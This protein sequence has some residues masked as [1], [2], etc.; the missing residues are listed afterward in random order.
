MAL[1]LLGV[2]I[3]IE[4]DAEAH[5]IVRRL[6]GAL[7]T[8]SRLLLSHTVTRPD[9]PDADA[10]VAF[11][12]GHGTLKPTRRPPG[13]VAGFFDGLQ[14][15]GPGGVPCN[16]WHPRPATWPSARRRPCTAEWH[17]SDAPGPG[18]VRAGRRRRPGGRS[19]PGRVGAEAA[20]VTW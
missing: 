12:K 16:H 11:R 3:L 1:T 18:P 10:A 17:A 4:D 6:M 7:P 19:A 14:L 15:L 20:Q 9:K 13:A 8:G 2:V 5:G